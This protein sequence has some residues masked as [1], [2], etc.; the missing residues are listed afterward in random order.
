[1]TAPDKGHLRERARDAI[2]S[3]KLSAETSYRAEGGPSPGGVCAVCDRELLPRELEYEVEFDQDTRRAAPTM[4]H[5]HVA[6][7]E[8]WEIERRL[9]R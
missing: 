5:L 9:A 2:L 1:M 8:A 4:F 7:F 3:G 6:C